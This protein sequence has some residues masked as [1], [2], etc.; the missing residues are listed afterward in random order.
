MKTNVFLR[1]LIFPLLIMGSLVSLSQDNKFGTYYNQKR[2]LFEKLPDTKG[3]I[4]FLGNSITDG[5]N[6]RSYWIIR[7]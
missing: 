3:E 2:T 7:K 1:G 6:G 4:V 5:E